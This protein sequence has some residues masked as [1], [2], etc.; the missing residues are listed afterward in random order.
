MVPR[1]MS[2]IAP[3]STNFSR[4][5]ASEKMMLA[6]FMSRCTSHAPWS[7]SVLTRSCCMAVAG[8]E[9]A[10]TPRAR[11]RAVRQSLRRRKYCSV[12]VPSYRHTSQLPA[13]TRPLASSGA[14]STYPRK[15][16][17]DPAAF[18]PAYT[19]SRCSARPT[20]SAS[21]TLCGDGGEGGGRQTGARRG[22]G[23]GN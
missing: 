9:A 17:H 21:S 11:P 6:G 5:S 15:S 20:S 14:T 18:C 1:R 16:A 22:G 4:F 19:L 10:D 2:A 8:A 23:G 3:K 13:V 7:L 12:L